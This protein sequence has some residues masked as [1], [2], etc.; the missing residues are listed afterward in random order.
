V[1]PDENESRREAQL[2]NMTVS[3]SAVPTLSAVHLIPLIASNQGTGGINTI[4]REC[5]QK[6][7]LEIRSALG[8]PDL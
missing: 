7:S 4:K 8:V 1:E 3:K 6:K 5:Q 2:L